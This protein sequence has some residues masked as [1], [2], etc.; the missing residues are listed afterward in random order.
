LP[1]A[2]E[3][4]APADPAPAVDG[5]PLRPRAGEP[6]V[7]ERRAARLGR[8]EACPCGVR[9]GAGASRGVGRTAERPTPGTPRPTADAGRLRPN[10]PAAGDAG[11]PVR[12]MRIRAGVR[13][14]LR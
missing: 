2:D 3:G 13:R 14:Y 8:R 11:S 7:P 1:Q 6:M 9:R 10:G 12:P 5:E 4:P